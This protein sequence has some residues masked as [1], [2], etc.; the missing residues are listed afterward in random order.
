MTQPEAHVL[1][2]LVTAGPCT[3]GALHGAFAHRRSTLTSVLDRLAARTL[4]ERASS[5]TDRRTFVVTLTPAGRE[6]AQQVHE[7]LRR[8]ERRAR[9]AVSPRDLEGFDRVLASL[10]RS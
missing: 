8:I 10:D 7:R 1:D 2:H 6:L 9:T 3:V 5:P 4:V